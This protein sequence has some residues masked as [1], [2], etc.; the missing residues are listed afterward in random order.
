ME[1]LLL[2]GALVLAAYW[3]GYLVGRAEAESSRRWRSRVE[4]ISDQMQDAR[5]GEPGDPRMN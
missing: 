3:V 4:R 1:L 2:V 5:I